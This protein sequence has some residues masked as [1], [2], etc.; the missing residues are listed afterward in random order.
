MDIKRKLLDNILEYY[1][2]K[3][4]LPHYEIFLEDCPD[5]C[6]IYY[7]KYIN[8]SPTYIHNGFLEKKWIN[9]HSFAKTVEALIITIFLHE[10]KHAID[11][12]NGKCPLQTKADRF[13]KQEINKWI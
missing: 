1:T 12:T 5:N 4:G 13:A 11:Y 10:I 8:L 6:H 2:C 7:G 3:Y 9:R